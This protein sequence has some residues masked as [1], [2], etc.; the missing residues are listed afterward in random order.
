M[1]LYVQ[2]KLKELQEAEPKKDDTLD[3][4]DEVMKLQRKFL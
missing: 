2:Q 1:E 4:T 3:P